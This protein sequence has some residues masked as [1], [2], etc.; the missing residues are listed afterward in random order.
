MI[1]IVKKIFLVPAYS[2]VAVKIN[3][4]YLRPASR[5]L[6]LGVVLG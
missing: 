6:I 4:K 3:F 5:I 1:V 2:K